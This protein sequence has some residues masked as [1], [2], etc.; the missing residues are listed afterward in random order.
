MSQAALPNNPKLY[1]LESLK[2]QCLHWQ[3]QGDTV[4]FTNGCFD[5]LHPGHVAYLQDAANL[6]HKLILGLNSDSSVK[7]LNK[8]PERPLNHELSRAFLLGGLSA[9]SA[10]VIFDEDNPLRLIAELKPNLLVKGADYDENENNPSSKKYI[11][12]KLE[13]EK[14]GGKVKSIPF[15]EGFSTTQLIEKIKRVG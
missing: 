11:V 15:I 13:V 12:G 5:I 9:I 1:S 3:N 7:R 4:V 10:I 14:Y 2:K 8:G 6:G